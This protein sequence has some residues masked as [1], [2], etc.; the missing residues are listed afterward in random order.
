VSRR[1]RRP[2]EEA[3]VRESG[4]SGHKHLGQSR[5]RRWSS[6]DT[7]PIGEREGGDGWS[8]EDE[9]AAG[10]NGGSGR[11]R[12]RRS[13]KASLAAGGEAAVAR[14]GQPARSRWRCGCVRCQ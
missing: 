11:V 2:G 7:T 5:R 4:M 8:S 1:R 3:A 13:G 10:P 6:E 9:A 12:R 14:C